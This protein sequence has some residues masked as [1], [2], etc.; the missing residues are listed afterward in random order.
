MSK[1]NETLLLEILKENRDDIKNMQLEFA[2]LKT[3]VNNHLLKHHKN[4]SI[5]KW[6]ITTVLAVGSLV[7]GVIALINGKPPTP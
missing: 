6:I 2:E 7:V 4:Q 3:A 5:G 1:E